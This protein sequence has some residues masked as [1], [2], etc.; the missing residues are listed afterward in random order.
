MVELPAWWKARYIIP[1]VEPLVTYE[2]A[3]PIVRLFP[4]MG[5]RGRV[6][7]YRTSI[8]LCAG[9]VE[10]YRRITLCAHD[11]DPSRFQV[12]AETVAAHR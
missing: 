11:Q 5:V 4:H 6:E 8:T 12:T 9:R 1:G 7:R 3:I 10:R 2:A